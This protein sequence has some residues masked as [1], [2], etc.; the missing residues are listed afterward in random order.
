MR[1]EVCQLNLEPLGLCLSFH[2]NY[3]GDFYYGFK[4]KW[5]F[6]RISTPNLH[7]LTNINREV[8]STNAPSL[9]PSLVK[10]NLGLM[11]HRG[12]S[13]SLLRI[14]SVPLCWAHHPP[15]HPLFGLQSDNYLLVVEQSCDGTALMRLYQVLTM[16]MDVTISLCLGYVWVMAAN[17]L[18]STP[19]YDQ[20]EYRL[21]SEPTMTREGNA[22]LCCVV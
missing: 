14:L 6:L 15:F 12:D 18:L 17:L 3:P 16:L 11:L 9:A 2:F 4:G 7:F 10:G 19:F 8:T 13:L 20:G 1:A 21:F 22:S 5:A